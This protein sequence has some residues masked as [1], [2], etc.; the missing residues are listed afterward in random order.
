MLLLINLINVK[1]NLD[2]FNK[3]SEEIDL[4]EFYAFSDNAI[5]QVHDVTTRMIA[6]RYAIAEEPATGMAAGNLSN[7]L[8][9][10]MG[11]KAETIIVE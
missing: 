3:V 11:Y 9:Y 4:I 8:Q 1:T 7:Y 2:E 6:P 10:K 5:D